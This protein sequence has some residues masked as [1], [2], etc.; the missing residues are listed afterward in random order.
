LFQ[1]FLAL[2]GDCNEAARG[3]IGLNDTVTILVVE[4]DQLIQAMVEEALSDGGFASAL[5]AS[6]EEAI[7]LLQDGK[8]KYRAVVTD[9]NVLGKLDGWEVGRAAREIDPTMPIIYMTGTHGEEWASKGVPN[10]VLLAKP[11]A[12]AQIVTAISKLLNATRRSRPQSSEPGPHGEKAEDLS[13]S[14]GFFD[15]AV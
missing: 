3:E 5:T 14:L 7:A 15:Q 13:T 4:D 2:P 6:G 1:H 8:S 12:P 10:S 9:I 11:F